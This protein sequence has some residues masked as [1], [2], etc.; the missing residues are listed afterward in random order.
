MT[1][2]N[3]ES[4]SFSTSSAFWQ[5]LAQSIKLPVGLWNGQGYHDGAEGRTIS[6]ISPRNGERLTDVVVASEQD[7]DEAVQRA[8]HA[9]DHGAWPR[10][11]P[12]ERGNILIAW[13][14]LLEKHRDELSLLVSLEMGKPISDAWNIELRTTI[15]LF[16]WYGELADKLMDETPWNRPDSLALVTREPLGVVAAITPWNFPLTLGAFKVPAALVAGNSVI[17]KPAEQSPLSALKLAELGA[18]A[19]LPPGVFQVLN[20]GGA[21]VGSTLVRHNN[22]ATVAFTGST[23]VGKQLLIDAGNSNAKPVWLELG[24]KSANVVFPDAPDMSAAIRSAAWAISFNAGQMCTAG[25]RLLVHR[26]IQDE[27]VDGVVAALR[28]HVIGDPL[29]PETTLGPLSSSHHRASVLSE[30]ESA[31]AAGASLRSG[32]QELPQ[33]QGPGWFVEPAVFTDVKLSDR[34]LQHEVFGP[35]LAVL[36]FEDEEE[37]LR[38]ANDTPFGLASA[39]WTSDLSRAHRMSR[40]IQAGT[41]WVNCYEEGDASVPFGGRKLS[42]H[43]LDKSEHGLSRFTATKTTWIALS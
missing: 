25:S 4:N 31:T 17:L 37:A 29:N 15:A 21:A 30:I 33:C 14:D 35:V 2:Q 11:H 6:L 18:E 36:T 43:G 32:S 38:I 9:F 34:L 42:G 20:G 40:G 22:V 27:F 10:M 1:T 24:G 12:R 39:V 28:D 26:S 5:D 41:V 23:E 19:G 7:V 3:S 13:A 16:R 8:K